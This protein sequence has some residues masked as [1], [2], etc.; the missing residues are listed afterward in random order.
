VDQPTVEVYERRAA[1]WIAR[2]R[3]PETDTAA[4]LAGRV[5]PDAW[6]VD[7]GCGPG[8]HLPHLGEPLVAFDAAYAMLHHAR[9]EA[10]SAACVQGDLEA[11][12]FR[13]GS[14]GG[15]WAKASYLHIPPERLPLALADLHDALAVGAPI[16]VT[17][18][19][20]SRPAQWSD[21]FQGRYF[22]AWDPVAIADV[23][24]GAGF[25]VDAVEQSSGERAEW[26]TVRATRLRTLADTVGP[27]M[28]LLVV[29]LNP[30][31]YA[32]DVGVAF[33]RPG[34]RFWPAAT[35]AGLVTRDRDPRH[36]AGAHGIGL[37]DLAKRATPRAH[38]LTDDEYQAGVVRVERLVEWL[39]PA[40]V[41]FAGLAGYRA[42]IAPRATA[43]WQSRAFGGRPAYAMPSPS[44]A[45]Q[46]ATVVSIAEHLAA[47][48]GGPTS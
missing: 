2:R 26:V 7:L 23:V 13:R 22:A 35:L 1:D 31:E 37:T 14:L 12:P 16:H 28:R 32:A 43:G 19:T 30:S 5:A 18:Q 44:G 9:S 6:R 29:G 47:A 46:Q 10:P 45:N 25:G 15:A 38:W 24:T 39:S 20:G 8:W 36:A 21:E 11:L 17:V 27:G 4:A 42:A 48:V 34:N 33:A 40:A 3:R 41:C